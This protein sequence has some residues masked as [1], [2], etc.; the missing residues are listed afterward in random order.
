MDDRILT[1]P[2]PP[3][4]L[5]RP[6]LS[7]CVSSD[8][9]TLSV[10]LFLTEVEATPSLPDKR[11]R[12]N[13]LSTATFNKDLGSKMRSEE[14]ASG[15]SSENESYGE[16]HATRRRLRGKKKNKDDTWVATKRMD[17]NSENKVTS[18]R[19]THSSPTKEERISKEGAEPLKRK[20]NKNLNG[21]NVTSQTNIVSLDSRQ[22]GNKIR[23][24]TEPNLGGKESSRNLEQAKLDMASVTSAQLKQ[25]ENEIH[26]HSNDVSQK[27]DV[28]ETN[29]KRSTDKIRVVTDAGTESSDQ[30]EDS[31]AASDVDSSKRDKGPCASTK[32]LLRTPDKDLRKRSLTLSLSSSFRSSRPSGDSPTRDNV[33]TSQDEEDSE[34]FSDAFDESP[35]VEI[36]AFQVIS[37][38]V[39]TIKPL[40]TGI[41]VD[42]SLSND[43]GFSFERNCVLRR[44]ERSKLR[45]SN[46]LRWLIYLI[47][48]VVD[49]LL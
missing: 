24:K 4:S 14:I 34:S 21:T 42:N 25:S 17:S 20:D 43:R 38:N 33:S 12:T 26:S 35:L 18:V 19:Y 48:L 27:S 41:I 11:T 46:L 37:S 3:F 31:E 23:G 13:S 47:D 15:F 28:Y 44:F 49:N 2:P 8:K 9:R 7:L 1:P 10:F 40:L 22:T 29:T 45:S 32:G 6:N 36:K 30:G 39:F 5:P 16:M